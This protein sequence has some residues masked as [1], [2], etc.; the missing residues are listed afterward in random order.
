MEWP[1]HPPLVR[2]GVCH[3]SL[4]EHLLTFKEI[5]ADLETLEV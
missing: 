3:A 1:A 4:E 2:G 5:V